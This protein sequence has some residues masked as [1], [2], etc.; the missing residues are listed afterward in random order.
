[1]ADTIRIAV[2]VNGGEN[3]LKTLNELEAKVKNLNSTPVKINVE[4]LNNTANAAEK[5]SKG[6]ESMAAATE[7]VET[8]SKGAT[9]GLKE[10]GDA[11]QKT[12]DTIF[13]AYKKMLLWAAAGNLIFGPIRAFKEALTTMKAVDDELVVV[14]KVTGATG[15]ELARLE[16]QAYATAS[17]YGVAADQFLNSVAAFSRAGYGDAAAGLAELATKTQL[18]GDV[19]Q[20]VANQFLLSVDAA[21]KY[22]GSIEKLSAVLDGA[23]EIDNKYATSI[24][25]IAEGL[26]IVAPVAAQ[27]GVGIDELTASIGTITAV[28]QRSGTEAARAFRALVLNIVGDTKTEIDEGVTWTTGEIAGLRDVIK[29]YAPEAYKAAQATGS[30]INPM[31]AIGGLAQSMKDGLLT[32]QQLMAMV[33]DIGGKLRS[34]QLLALIQNWDMYQSMLGDYA[35]AIGSA[36]REVANA[37]DSWT[38][39]SE[40]LNNKWTEFVSNLVNTDAIK[41]G[42]DV[43]IRLVEGL[44]TNFGRAV[45]T[46]AAITAGIGLLVAGVK[47]IA[48]AMA[49]LNLEMLANPLFLAGAGL[50][51]IFT[52]LGIANDLNVTFDEQAQ[53]VADINKQLEEMAG[54]GSEYDTL[55]NKA[56]DLTEI[57]KKRLEYLESQTAELRKQAA[58]ENR[59]LFEKRPGQS[60]RVANPDFVAPALGGGWETPVTITEDEGALLKTSAALE[61][62]T[63]NYQNGTAS[64][65]EY[66]NGIR[67]LISENADYVEKLVEWRDMGFELTEVENERI[68]QYNELLD[69]SVELTEQIGD[70]ND[71][72]EEQGEQQK[73]YTEALTE[74]LTE[75][76]NLQDAYETLQGAVDEFN[77]S[78]QLSAE[79]LIALTQNDLLQYLEFTENGLRINEQALYDQAE[80]ARIAAIQ[81]LQD[82]AAQDILA[83][84][85]GN[86]SDLSPIA[87]GA[88]AGMGNNAATAGNQAQTAAGQVAMLAGSLQMMIEAAQ[89]NLSG[90][91]DPA[92]FAAQANA[93]KDRYM[94]VANQIAGITIRPSGGGGSSRRSGGGGSGKKGGSSSKSTEKTEEEKLEE[95]YKEMKEGLKDTLDDMEHQIFLWEKKGNMSTA[96]VEQYRK[97]QEEIHALAQ[98]YRD[99]G[100]DE[101]S[102][103]IQDLQKQWWKYQEEIEKIAEDL[104]DELEDAVDKEL[105]AA[106]AAKDKEVAAIDAQIDA[107]KNAADKEDELLTIEE[108]RLA[109]LEAQE[110]LLKAQEQRNVRIYNAA[111]GQWEWTADQNAVN[112]AQE[113]LDEAQ[114]DLEDFT[115]EL[116]LNEEIAALEERKDAIEAAYDAFEAEWKEILKSIEEPGRSIGEILADINENGTPAMK[117]AVDDVTAILRSLANY[118][119]GVSDA[120][121][122]GSLT[123]G[124]GTASGYYAGDKTDYSALMLSAPDEATFRYYA[125]QRSAKIAAQGINLNAQGYLSNDDLYAQWKGSHYDSGGILRGMGGI[126][127]TPRDEAVLPPTL[128]A[129]MMSPGSS[130]VFR[131]RLAQLGFLYGSNDATALTRNGMLSNSSTSIFNN[132][133]NYYIDGVKISESDANT[134]TIAKVAERARVLSL[135]TAR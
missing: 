38:R 83:L 13:S 92:T 63:E 133:S 43:V 108:K 26:G 76:K 53:I 44:N 118:N 94:A 129:A 49:A 84:A 47:S 22:Q 36:D 125:A 66:R 20:E 19:N 134:L 2:N 10:T 115:K 11:A 95:A 31:E 60:N 5:A 15:E 73:N 105:E 87:A 124:G 77:T 35:N 50:A 21:Y 82:A 41:T 28:T 97:M 113:A 116:A 24:Q 14:R 32:E 12:G 132:G 74:S 117:Q 111:T 120:Y 52:I 25:K 18:V 23:N 55:K 72:L 51:G 68:E 65:E 89:G 17:A 75:L 67:G 99:M 79:T 78:G 69:L 102:E 110:N 81:S 16:K 54:P 126:K 100:L 3:A 29:Q 91:M 1:M 88:I 121:T 39:K 7:K 93:I 96:I 45:V 70:Q 61:K 101:N 37:L 42:L 123:G 48:I 58:E 34:S 103:Y 59:K 71:V 85:T 33:S 4:G 6:M 62:I 114:A 135:Y 90:G 9:K 27:V 8:A 106:E 56:G 80:A 107:L 131:E 109:V 46:A 128:T 64:M 30:L 112:A 122:G 127:A 104:W 130:K 57:E 86:V 40:R 98:K 119:R